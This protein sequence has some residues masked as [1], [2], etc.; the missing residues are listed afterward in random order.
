MIKFGKVLTNLD[1]FGKS[2][3]K[4]HVGWMVV[5]LQV[6]GKELQRSAKRSSHEARSDVDAD[7]EIEFDVML[8][9][10][11]GHQVVPK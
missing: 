11:N 5:I 10:P 7:F 3:N 2:L 6:T 4:S 8:T 9:S 1:R